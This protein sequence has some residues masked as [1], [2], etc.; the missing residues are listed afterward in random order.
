MGITKKTY[1][2]LNQRVTNDK[3]GKS[4]SRGDTFTASDFDSATIADWL[5]SG[6]IKEAG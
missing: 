6:V 2:V 1:I 3:T 5:E 4:F